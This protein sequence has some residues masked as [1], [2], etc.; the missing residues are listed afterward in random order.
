MH[1]FSG[2]VKVVCGAVFIAIVWRNSALLSRSSDC[3]TAAAAVD[4]TILRA[5]AAAAVAASGAIAMECRARIP[6]MRALAEEGLGH[7]IDNNKIRSGPNQLVEVVLIIVS[8]NRL[9]DIREIV[10]V[11]IVDLDEE[12]NV[13]HV[14]V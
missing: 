2:T 3:S 5:T 8:G 11:A 6:A 13:G 1:I 14:D 12:W 7:V 10:L 9:P 4:N